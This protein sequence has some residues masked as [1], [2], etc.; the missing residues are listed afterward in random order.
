[1][2]ASCARA[3][4][5]GSPTG[6]VTFSDGIVFQNPQVTSGQGVFFANN[7][8]FT[9][10]VGR[11][12]SLTLGDWSFHNTGASGGQFYGLHITTEA[13]TLDTG[14]GIAIQNNGRADALYIGVSGKSGAT[15]SSPTGI[16]LNVNVSLNNFP[17]ENSPVNN[18]RGMQIWD[19]SQTDQ[20]PGGPI[21]LLLNKQNKSYTGHILEYITNC[22]NQCLHINV[23][24]NAGSSGTAPI[25]VQAQDSSGKVFWQTNNN[26]NQFYGNGAQL[27]GFSDNLRSQTY[28][29]DTAAG[30]IYFK[31]AVRPGSN[32]LISAAAPTVASGFGVSPSIPTNNGT[33][34]FTVN[35]GA[36]GAAAS[37]TIGLPAAANGWNCWCN[38]LTTQSS[39]VF[40]CKQ[41][42][43]STTTATLA[44]YSASGAP[45][46]WAAGDTLAVS[47]FA[48]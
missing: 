11:D 18:G 5:S 7:S 45:A 46:A 36:G 42:A 22:D 16:G 38:D 3:Q 19:F 31:G 35:V 37:G 15:A 9:A 17:N 4:S 26:G 10:A 20:G 44:N 48:R 23:P 43:S 14:A 40:V 8:Q 13:D 30:D 33:A 47:C 27:E 2:A 28:R 25:I 39:A 21:A 1:L 32:V 41:T 6:P 29:V 12:N 34:S 24:Q